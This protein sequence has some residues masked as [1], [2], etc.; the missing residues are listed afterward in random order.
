MFSFPPAFAPFLDQTVTITVRSSRGATP[1]V[2][3]VPACVSAASPEASAIAE[4]TLG[5]AVSHTVLIREQTVSVT[6]GSTIEAGALL[7]TVQTAVAQC[8]FVHIQC[9]AKEGIAR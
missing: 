2:L 5:V 8:G 3:T 7:L 6:P 9:S 1:T 4:Q